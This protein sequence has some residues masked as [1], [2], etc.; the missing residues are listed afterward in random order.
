MFLD[1]ETFKNDYKRKLISLYR[2]SVEDA[3]D[4][5]KYMALG[6]LIKDYMA[7]DWHDTEV[8]YEREKRKQVYYFSLEYLIGRLMDASLVNLGIRDVVEEGLKDFGVELKSLE[9]IEPE[10]GIDKL[11]PLIFPVPVLAAIAILVE[12][13]V[14]YLFALSFAFLSRSILSCS[15]F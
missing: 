6:S 3:N 12:P 5:L 7:N 15:A 4:T 1:K 8:K 11:I 14:L 9:E 13:D 10:T 2:E